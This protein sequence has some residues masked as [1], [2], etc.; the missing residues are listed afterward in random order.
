MKYE[1]LSKRF[2]AFGVTFGLSFSL[3]FLLVIFATL[4]GATGGLFMSILSLGVVIFAIR[5]YRY[6]RGLAV[7]A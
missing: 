7:N 1:F 4:I 5:T 3:F 6:F 2:V